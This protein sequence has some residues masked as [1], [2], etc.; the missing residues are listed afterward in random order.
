[1]GGRP[2]PLTRGCFSACRF[3]FL[4]RA[5]CSFFVKDI[6]LQAENVL[7]ETMEH[8]IGTALTDT[9]WLQCTL[10]P[11]QGGLGI[12]S[13]HTQ[14]PAASVAGLITWLRLGQEH[15]PRGVPSIPLLGSPESLHWLRTAVGMDIQPLK[16]LGRR[17]QFHRPIERTR[18]TRP[19]GR[20]DP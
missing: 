17:R 14:A 15:R 6:L 7:R 12:D 10:A 3:T 19:L 1:M 20:N 18:G 13:P 16:K 11:A 5:T 9:Q 4:S 8:I 2:L